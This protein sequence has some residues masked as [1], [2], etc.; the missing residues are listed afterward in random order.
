[1]ESW[2]LL[3]FVSFQAKT[4]IESIPRSSVGH[5]NWLGVFV[6]ATLKNTQGSGID[7]IKLKMS[8]Y[9][10]YLIFKNLPKMRVS[11]KMSQQEQD[12][13]EQQAQQ[14]QAQQ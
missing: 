8:V 13:H 14:Q 9:E 12:Q 3:R 5:V 2:R 11:E 7:V 10:P 1:M 4:R 6:L